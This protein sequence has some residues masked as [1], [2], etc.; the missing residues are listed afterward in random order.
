MINKFRIFYDA[1]FTGLHRDTSLISIG[2]VSQSG[3]YF[4]AEFNDYDKDQI[5]DWIHENVIN[6][7]IMNN[8]NF[9]ISPLPTSKTP[10][11]VYNVVLKADK[12][13]VS[14]RLLSWIAHSTQIVM[15]MIGYYS[16]I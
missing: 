12:A 2:L 5:T 1:E 9:H 11:G 8:K 7:L 4:Y 16:M 15:H 3:S 13:E 14:E 10:N 6:N